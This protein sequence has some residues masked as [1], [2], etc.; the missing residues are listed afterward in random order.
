MFKTLERVVCTDFTQKILDM[1]EKGAKTEEILPLISGDKVRTAYETGE[2]S[3]AIITAGQTVG[4][5]H[6]IPSVKEIID[7]IILEAGNIIKRLNRI[8]RG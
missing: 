8:E 6:N 1:E 2:T 4:L 7:R 5:I 3:N